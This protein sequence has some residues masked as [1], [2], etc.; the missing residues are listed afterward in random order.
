MPAPASIA[1]IAGRGNLSAA[2]LTYLLK[3]PEEATRLTELLEKKFADINEGARL[4]E[5]TRRNT[6][7][8]HEKLLAAF[9]AEHEAKTVDIAEARRSVDE[10]I[11][12]HAEKVAADT[13]D[14]GKRI[15]DH[16]AEKAKFQADKTA[17]EADAMARADKIDA[18]R[19]ALEERETAIQ[20]RETAC[21]NTEALQASQRQQLRDWLKE[22]SDREDA[23]AALGTQIAR[24][25]RPSIEV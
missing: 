22:L 1:A 10:S 5:E 17:F 14:L 19:K 2:D 8:E 4:L 24:S 21:A 7:A 16:A 9:R 23:I 6:A 15:S 11:R 20:A 3:N 18:D 13:A 25:T 12:A